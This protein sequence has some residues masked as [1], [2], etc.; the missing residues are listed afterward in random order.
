MVHPE[1]VNIGRRIN[2][3]KLIN[4]LVYKLNDPKQ[5]ARIEVERLIVDISGHIKS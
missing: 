3:K 5:I 1:S 4:N 2:L